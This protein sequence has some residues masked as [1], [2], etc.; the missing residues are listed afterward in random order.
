MRTDAR[1]EDEWCWAWE[2]NKNS[3]IVVD[4]P[5]RKHD[6][7]RFFTKH[8]QQERQE[9]QERTACSRAQDTPAQDASRHKPIHEAAL[10]MQHPRVKEL[11]KGTAEEIVS[12]TR[13]MKQIVAMAAAV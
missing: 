1:Q 6:I 8:I 11:H 9:R 4:F 3:K 12:T 10:G 13:S 2:Y 5:A 7:L